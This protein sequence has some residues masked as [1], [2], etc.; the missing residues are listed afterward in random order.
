MG[1]VSRDVLVRGELFSTLRVV[2]VGLGGLR[3][4]CF[5]LYR[6]RV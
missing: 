4:Q 5:R 1:S 2:A 6:L 3:M